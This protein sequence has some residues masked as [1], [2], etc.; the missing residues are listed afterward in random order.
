MLANVP[1]LPFIDR[2]ERNSLLRTRKQIQRSE[3]SVPGQIAGNWQSCE[4]EN[5]TLS[6]HEV[7]GR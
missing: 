5:S 2:S 3:A 7:I 1:L 4:D 6:L